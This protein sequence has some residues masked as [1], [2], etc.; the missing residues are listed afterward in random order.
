MG[1]LM[2][3]KIRPHL[4]LSIVYLSTPYRQMIPFELKNI[5]FNSVNHEKDFHTI[6]HTQAEYKKRT[7]VRKLVSGQL[8]PQTINSRLLAPDL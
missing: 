4:N 6:P 2:E 7:G 8:A 5:K 3:I 1:L